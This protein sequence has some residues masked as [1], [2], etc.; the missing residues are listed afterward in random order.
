MTLRVASESSGTS[1]MVGKVYL[2]D[3]L[4]Q[5]GIPALALAGSPRT[6]PGENEGNACSSTA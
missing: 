2:R 6:G 3:V 5:Q 1:L 4:Q